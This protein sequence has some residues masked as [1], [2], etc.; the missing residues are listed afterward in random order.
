MILV[1]D[2]SIAIKWI[3]EESNS[4]EA[5]KLLPSWNGDNVNVADMSVR[6]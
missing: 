4:A 6:L 2:C 1:V 5:R 3:A